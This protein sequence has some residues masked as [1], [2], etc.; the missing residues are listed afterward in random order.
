[1]VKAVDFA[2]E[3]PG[4]AALCSHW[5]DAVKDKS[6]AQKKKSN[7][8]FILV[9]I[10]YELQIYDDWLFPRHY[11]HQQVCFLDVNMLSLQDLSVN[12]LVDNLFFKI[13]TDGNCKRT[14]DYFIVVNFLNSIHGH[15][16]ALMR[17]DK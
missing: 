12:Y 15:N 13:Q 7:F 14:Q 17:L 16:K 6:S 4:K 5:D 11:L 9:T 3:T 8:D 10:K 1:M 2:F